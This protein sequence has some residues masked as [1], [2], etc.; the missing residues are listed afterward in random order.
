LAFWMGIRGKPL[1]IIMVG[2]SF[3]LSMV[4]TFLLL[5]LATFLSY[6]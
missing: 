2:G 5:S 6:M 1:Q 4:G 3:V